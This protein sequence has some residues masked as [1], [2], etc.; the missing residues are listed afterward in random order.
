M[1]R[2]ITI[3]KALGALFWGVVLANLLAPFAQPFALLLYLAG[4]AM[5]LLHAL[6]L[7]AFKAR[8]STCP[9]PAL[10]AGQIMMF[11]IFHLLSLPEPEAPPAEQPSAATVL[12]VEHA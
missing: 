1:K 2:V 12:E 6:E 4:A 10:Q 8:W 11:G 9:Q 7:L 5:V 3:G